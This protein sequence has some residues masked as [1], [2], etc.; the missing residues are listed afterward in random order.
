MKFRVSRKCQLVNQVPRI[1]NLIRRLALSYVSLRLIS[2]VLLSR[3]RC[4]NLYLHFVVVVNIDKVICDEVVVWHI[5]IVQRVDMSENS[6]YIS[7][8]PRRTRPQLFTRIFKAFC[9]YVAHL[10]NRE[11]AL[12]TPLKLLIQK[13]QHRKV[14]RPDV[15]S[16]GEINIIVR[17]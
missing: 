4:D 9:L 16:S 13:V 5:S 10:V 7:D 17:V 14:K 11:V 12:L 2:G 3:S 8:V 1:Y 6:L 15:I